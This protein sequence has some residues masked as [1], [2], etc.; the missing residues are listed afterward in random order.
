MAQAL[1]SGLV[2]SRREVGEC[3]ILSEGR[4]VK[5]PFVA[6]SRITEVSWASGADVMI[7]TFE[8]LI[9]PLVGIAAKTLKWHK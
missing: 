5:R 6:A 9:D 7:E 8:R 1:N 2:A 4:M 3:S